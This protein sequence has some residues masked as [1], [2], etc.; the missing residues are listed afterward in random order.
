MKNKN[1]I[2]LIG[3]LLITGGITLLDFENPAFEPN[4]KAYFMLIGGLV[5]L[6]FGFLRKSPKG[7]SDPK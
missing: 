7:S 5:V 1:A 3:V 6:I 4:S 2:K